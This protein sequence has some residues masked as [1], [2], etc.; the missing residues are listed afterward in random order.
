MVPPSEERILA[1]QCDDAEGLG[2]QDGIGIGRDDTVSDGIVRLLA[3]MLVSEEC[4]RIHLQRDSRGMFPLPDDHP[5]V[6]TQAE[7]GCGQGRESRQPGRRYGIGDIF[8]AEIAQRGC[9]Q[10]AVQGGERI[11]RAK[12]GQITGDQ[13]VIQFETDRPVFGIVHHATQHHAEIKLHA[14]ADHERTQVVLVGHIHGGELVILHIRL[15]TSRKDE[16]RNTK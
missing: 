6:F 7:K 12:G 1:T 8:L 4:G 15:V 13:L 14:F 3:H 5:A 9:P 10:H 2:E 16:E 11:L